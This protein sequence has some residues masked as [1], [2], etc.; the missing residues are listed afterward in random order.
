MNI[1]DLSSRVQR[2]QPAVHEQVKQ[3]TLS[4]LQKSTQRTTRFDQTL[5][6]A[7][8]GI[9]QQEQVVRL[10]AHAVH[11]LEERN[12]SLTSQER[13]D[14]GQAITRLSDKGARNALIVRDDAA[15]VV[16]VP[17]R[18]LVTAISQQE[19][20]QRVFTQIDSTMLI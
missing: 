13:T 8:Q 18:T 2:S 16:N 3:K 14:L 11:R 7:Q 6:K 12:I 10:S 4:P 20:Q 15:F 1:R 5:E 19:L 17:N 9:E